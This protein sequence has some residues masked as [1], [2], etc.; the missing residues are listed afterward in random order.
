[1]GIEIIA[2]GIVAIIACGIGLILRIKEEIEEGEARILR[3][4]EALKLKIGQK[5]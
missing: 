1:M 5:K 3:S 2:I 4:I